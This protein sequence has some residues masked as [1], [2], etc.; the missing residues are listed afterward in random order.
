MSE[1]TFLR[2]C[3]FEWMSEKTAILVSHPLLCLL[4][5]TGAVS[6]GF[7]SVTPFYL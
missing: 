6:I 7:T 2:A 5:L 1:R 4:A 3:M